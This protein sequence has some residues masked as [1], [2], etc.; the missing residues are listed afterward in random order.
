MASDLHKLST[1]LVVN[2]AKK[3]GTESK[4]GPSCDYN[5]VEGEKKIRKKRRRN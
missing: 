5:V 1:G 4:E 2:G 3:K